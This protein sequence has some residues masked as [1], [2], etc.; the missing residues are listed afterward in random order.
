MDPGDTLRRIWEDLVARPSGPMG[1]RLILQPLMAALLATRD[2]VRDA[3]G[4]R[5]PYL[6]TLVKEPAR[7]RE[8]LLEGLRAVSKVMVLALL[9]DT[10]YQLLF[11]GRFHIAEA[12]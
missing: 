1:L 11:V 4:E 8:L 10:A 12:V 2:G 6:R 3:R 9:L 5:P 7:R